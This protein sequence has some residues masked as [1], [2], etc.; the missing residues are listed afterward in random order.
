[1]P[2][3]IDSIQPAPGFQQPHYEVTYSL[4]AAGRSTPVWM[5]A[6][7][8]AKLSMVEVDWFLRNHWSRATAADA[9]LDPAGLRTINQFSGAES[10]ARAPEPPIA[11][12]I[13]E[14]DCEFCTRTREAGV[15]P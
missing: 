9:A 3:M 4:S 5:K 2:L 11:P 8:P 13:E 14:C 1:M 15:T 7:V 10:T 6:F 12:T